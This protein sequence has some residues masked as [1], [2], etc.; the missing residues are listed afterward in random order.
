MAKKAREVENNLPIK[1]LL[2]LLFN[3]TCS[4]PQGRNGKG[5]LFVFGA[6]NEGLFQDSCGYDGYITSIHTLAISVVNS[7]GKKSNVS[8]RCPAII[9]VTQTRDG[10]KGVLS[11]V[12]PMVI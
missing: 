6:G 9:G 2:C 10:A 1:T 5:S 3:V 4:L 8:E 7:D 12:D 11:D